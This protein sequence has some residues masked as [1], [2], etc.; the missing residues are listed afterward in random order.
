MTKYIEQKMSYHIVKLHK[1]YQFLKMVQNL[2]SNILKDIDDKKSLGQFFTS[3]R[4]TEYIIKQMNLDETKTVADLSC[5]DGAFLNTCFNH[6]IKNKISPEQI[7]SNIYGIEIH[8]KQLNLAKQNL[9]T[10]AK[11]N[12]K[13]IDK[14]IILENTIQSTPEKLL[15]KFPKIAKQKGFDVI[16]G[17]PPY[18]S[19][20]TSKFIK[21][22]PILSQIVFGQVNSATLMIGRAYSLLKEGGKLGLLLPKSILRVNSYKKLRDFLLTKFC[23]EELIDV[24][25]EFDDVRGEQFILIA[26]KN[27]LKPKTIKIGSFWKNKPFETHMIPFNEITKFDNFLLLENKKLYKLVDKIVSDHQNL[28]QCS[29]GK[30]YRGI[31]IGANSK[32]VST[33]PR[34]NFYKGLRGDSI[35]KFSYDYLIHIQKRDY[36][37]LDMVRTKKIVL[38]NIFSSESG[39]IANYDNEGLVTLD[40]VTNIL[41]EKENPYYVLG[42]LNSLLIRFFMV[43]A[44]YDKSRLTMHADRRYISRIPI[45]KTS[46]KLKKAIIN[47]VKNNSK[48]SSSTSKLNDL[49]FEVFELA[50]SEKSQVINQLE[51]FDQMGKK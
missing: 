39:I 48:K 46:E 30:I 8:E 26:T 18:L 4:I 11:K 12:K 7:I 33:S 3:N 31:G 38:Q 43:F 50:D 44:I 25:I 51:K 9:V 15:E 2:E 21:S 5:G 6:L 34:N 41:L 20:T 16:V 24:G 35:K 37:K 14:N 29:N 10:I 40:T 19:I 45:P 23:I 36:P 1:K 49:V 22:D 13:I 42:I 47:E 28:D 17:N 32:Y 27:S